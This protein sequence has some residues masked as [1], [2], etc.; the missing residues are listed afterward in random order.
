MPIPHDVPQA[1]SGAE[2]ALPLEERPWAPEGPAG[3][4]DLTRRHP[5]GLGVL[6]PSC[7]F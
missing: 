3:L 4:E 7:A 6:K 1:P 2:A 5:A